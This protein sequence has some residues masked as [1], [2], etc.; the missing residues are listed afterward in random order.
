MFAAAGA[1]GGAVLTLFISPFQA[2]A[3]DVV[4]ATPVIG[5]WTCRSPTGEVHR[6]DVGINPG[7]I[8]VA[9]D[10]SGKEWVWVANEGPQ[11]DGRSDS[12][13]M[14]DPERDEL[15]RTYEVGDS[16]SGL[17]PGPDGRVYF[18]DCAPRE[19]GGNRCA[20]ARLSSFDPADLDGGEVEELPVHPAGEL[21]TLPEDASGAVAAR[22]GGVAYDRSTKTLWAS[23][24]GTR[25]V[26]SIRPA[27]GAPPT[28]LPSPAS[29]PGK[30]SF[31]VPIIDVA[32]AGQ[33]A[34]FAPG[35]KFANP[36]Q[37]EGLPG[38]RAL[39]WLERAA[40]GT[41]R[42]S[43]SKI[44]VGGPRH[45]VSRDSLF[46]TLWVTSEGDGSLHRISGV[47]VRDGRLV[48]DV[49]K[50]RHEVI[51]IGGN[52][53]DLDVSPEAVWVPDSASGEVLRITPTG[54]IDPVAGSL[55]V[56]VAA[57]LPG[58]PVAVAA[59]GA[60]RNDAV[61]AAVRSRAPDEQGW[62][63][64]IDPFASPLRVRD[65]P[66]AELPGPITSRGECLDS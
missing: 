62:V 42:R 24:W 55:R 44:C 41:E 27:D 50:A 21:A 26:F 36:A 28:S 3:K 63:S 46:G 60:R 20:V 57:D 54:S 40:D 58:R 59:S 33:S 6:I 61:W 4:C 37:V 13:S 64:R 43:D 45:W 15:R 1:L 47:T 49:S 38:L 65:A 35:W 23:V 30:P 22:P 16:P 25:Q 48:E 32:P 5:G 31:A 8:M 14:I 39:W 34:W 52:P 9:R 66:A 56:G 51:S 12:I 17:S 10:H 53:M 29:E 11:D 7:S 18:T 19:P 2:P